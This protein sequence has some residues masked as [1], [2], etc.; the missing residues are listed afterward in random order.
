M[1]LDLT[2]A[3]RFLAV[4]AVQKANSGHP[5]MPL[6]MADVVTVLFK[7]FLK[8]D[9]RHP[10]WPDRDRFVLS[11][12][13]GSML[14]YAILFLVG[15]KEFTIRQIRNF[16][17]LGSKTAGHP[18]YGHAPGIE[19]TTG[20]LGQGLANA[21]GMAISEAMLTARFG[22]KIVNHFTYVIAGDGC[23]M[24]GISHEAISLAGHLKLSKLIVFWDDNQISI[25]GNTKLTTAE[26]HLKRF[27]ACGWETIEISG[28]D[29]VSVKKAI[30]RAKQSNMP[31]LIACKTI[32]GFGS[33]N[34]AGSHK[35]HGAPL[36]VNEI[37]KMREELG[38]PHLPFRIPGRVLS[39]WRSIGLKGAKVRLRWEKRVNEL[40]RKK[41]QSFKRV[42]SGSLPEGWEK[43]IQLHKQELIKNKPSLA[44][45]QAS[46]NCLE[47]LTMSVPELIGGS[48]DLT[49]SVNTKAS[50]MKPVQPEK[51]NG[52]YIHYGVRE[53]AMAA[54]M[55]GITLHGGFIPY[56]GTF[57]VFADY[58]RPAIRL[59]SL[60]GQRVIY[61][62]T[63]DS[64][65]LGEDGPTHQPVETLA[66]L[67][68]IPNLKVFRP[69]DPVETAECW[70][71]A[72]LND[73]GPSCLVLTRQAVPT[74]RTGSV[75]YNKSKK[76]AYVLLEASSGFHKRKVTLLATGSEVSIAVDARSTLENQGIAT[77]VVS[78]PCFELFLRQKKHNRI[79]VLGESPVRVGIEA[80]VRFGWDRFL[81]KND[82]F[83]G[84]KSFGAS[85]P[86]NELF[87]YFEIT[88]KKVVEKVK[89]RI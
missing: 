3:I 45:R 57:L 66:S 33:P 11:A 5:G 64:I 61:V 60:M 28:H 42:L 77:A 40:E 55:N 82:G 44:T 12:G 2:N 4:D 7:D 59:S 29:P 34:L 46:G 27:Q 80:A 78:I 84:M 83:V 25:D 16:R 14:L 6:G 54:L 21:V 32:I 31:T 74:L 53:H 88:S 15:Y 13:H 23:L 49:G 73:S 89:A 85:A 81:R 9:P 79:Q 22:R 67:R 63:H 30:A 47:I 52:R 56:G 36:G 26:N 10:K 58:M 39:R 72:L 86:G 68:A 65:G 24:E 69:C 18:E 70:E 62:L 76:G 87:E 50:T 20:P 35:T 17:Q 41:L 8:F 71:L 38:W 51:F 75:K 43:E 48:A 1:H 37:K 19:T